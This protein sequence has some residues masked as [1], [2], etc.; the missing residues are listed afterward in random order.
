M[1]LSHI[2][3]LVATIAILCCCCSFRTFCV[4]GF[5]L[6]IMDAKGVSSVLDFQGIE[7]NEEVE[8]ACRTRL[9]PMLEIDSKQC[10]QII[11]AA[12][13]QL[14]QDEWK[15]EGLSVR[16]SHILSGTSTALEVGIDKGETTRE[17]SKYFDTVHGFDFDFKCDK[18][19][20]TLPSNVKLHCSTLKAIMDSYNW[21]LMKFI[22]EG[23][24]ADYV[25]LDGAHTWNIDA[26]AFLLADRILA[27]GGV[28]EFDDYGWY[29]G[30]SQ[31]SLNYWQNEHGGV[32]NI[33]TDEQVYT[34][35]VALVVD[36]LVKRDSRYE[37]LVKNRVYRKVR[38]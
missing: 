9:C 23:I 21:D 13:Q 35:Q 5:E 1:S 15:I 22:R 10:S 36:L 33:Y 29:I 34:P 11:D 26:L 2:P 19:K 32:E 7:T 28:V 31:S 27:V 24:R 20:G 8:N 4:E 3:F 14:N 18:L 17:L 6:N 37:E 12:I 16:P 25:Y 30:K 38:D